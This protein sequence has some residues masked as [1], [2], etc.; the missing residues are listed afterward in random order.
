MIVLERSDPFAMGRLKGGG[1]TYYCIPGVLTSAQTTRSAYSNTDVY[2]PFFVATPIRVDQVVFEVTTLAAANMRVG[3]Y[4]SDRD[5][6]PF[7]S[8]LCDSG[9]ISIGTIGIKTYTPGTPMFLP[10]GRYLGVRNASATGGAL[11]VVQ[12]AATAV[13]A[14][15]SNTPFVWEITVTRT[16]EAFPTPPTA[17]NAANTGS[18]GRP[19]AIVYRVV[20][21]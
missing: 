21:P 5:W 10:R 17:W 16:Y 18:T 14:T 12:V 19:Q 13:L 1:V 2:E 11:R 15:M 7:G 9:D 3:I 8:P 20:N 6:Q 4:R